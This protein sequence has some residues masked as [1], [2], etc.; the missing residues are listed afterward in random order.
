MKIRSATIDDAAQL[1][2][3]Y[4]PFIENTAVSFETVVPSTEEFARRITKRLSSWAWLV[5]E[6]DGRC[7]GYVCGHEHRPRAAYRWSVEVSAYVADS[8][9]RQ[10]IARKLYLE[11]FDVLAQQG[12]CNA[13]AGVALPNDASVALHRGVGFEPIGTFARVGWK[14]DR[15]HDVAWFQRRLRDVPLQDATAPAPS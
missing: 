10:G 8:H 5:A 6:V 1:L 7:V 11:L 14:F 15:W 4:A 9:H 3:I 2:A 13:Y 12:Y